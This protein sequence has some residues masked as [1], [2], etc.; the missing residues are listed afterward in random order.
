MGTSFYNLAFH[1]ELKQSD[2]FGEQYGERFEAD[3]GGA[4]NTPM[5]KDVQELYNNILFKFDSLT[6]FQEL[7]LRKIFEALNNVRSLIDP[8]R[9]KPFEQYFNEDE[10]LLLYRKTDTGLI[11]II[12]NPEECIAFSYLTADKEKRALIFYD[13]TSDFESLVYKFFS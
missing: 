12:I 7:M 3:N 1:E 13:E 2:L 5:F 9:L 4:F 6:E 11:N 10:E 8:E